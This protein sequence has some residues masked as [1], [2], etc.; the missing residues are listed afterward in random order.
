MKKI[1]IL[2]ALLFSF[3]SGHD[4]DGKKVFQTYCW[5]CHH[6]TAMAFGPPFSQIAAK[7]SKA[8]I[9]AYIASPKSMYKAFG[10]KRTVMTQLHLNAKELDAIS[11]YILSYKGK[12]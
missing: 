12:K 6:Q 5:G 9:E 7:R 2:I 11:D 8:E 4:S 1:T 3:A 10:Y